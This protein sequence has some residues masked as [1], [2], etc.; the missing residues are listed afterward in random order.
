MAA[1]VFGTTSRKAAALTGTEMSNPPIIPP[2]AAGQ[3]LT[4]AHI[5]DVHI[6]DKFNAE[7]WV[8][9]ALHMIQSH[10]KKP[11]IILNTGDC[12]MDTARQKKDEALHLWNV[13]KTTFKRENS[14]P[15]HTCLG[16]HDVWG[17]V[18]KLDTPLRN[19]PQF[20]RKLALDQLGMDSPYHSFDAGGWH[21]I[22]L[23]SVFVEKYNGHFA[24]VGRLDDKQ[25]AWLEA[26]LAKT[27]ADKPVL[28]CSHIPIMQVASMNGMKPDK[29]R[30]YTFT[31]RWMMGDAHKFVAL[32]RKHPNVKLCLSGHLH[33]LDRLELNY[34]TYICD[35]SV[36]G[37]KWRGASPL[38]P[39]GFSILTLN[40]NGSFE[41]E[42]IPIGWKEGVIPKV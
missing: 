22:M 15:L 5:T 8:S 28:V 35:G 25:W 34:T 17:D 39:P 12:V 21:I 18:M 36:C 14:L 4:I 30:S 1:G 37:G 3:P 2:G 9:K 10:P 33:S 23:D 41:Y 32:F 27:P 13:W 19:D 6:I 7:Q 11:S 40:P 31:E 16:N 42:Y 38:H 20:G 29:D 24:W 26:D